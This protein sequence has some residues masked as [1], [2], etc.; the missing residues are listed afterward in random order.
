MD[1]LSKALDS[2]EKTFEDTFP[3]FQMMSKSPEEIIEI[4]EECISKKK[5][6]YELG[7]LKLDN[8]YIY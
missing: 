8:D 1:K 2:Y 4:I 7:Y 5:D 3:T 6:V